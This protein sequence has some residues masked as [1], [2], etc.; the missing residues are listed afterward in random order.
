MDQYDRH[1]HLVGQHDTII[2]GELLR[3]SHDDAV[4]TRTDRSVT[5]VL[6]GICFVL[7]AIIVA[8]GGM[9]WLAGHGYV[10]WPPRY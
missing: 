9:E 3:K 10:S 8:I 6:G 1:R 5:R 4:L 2:D 7:F